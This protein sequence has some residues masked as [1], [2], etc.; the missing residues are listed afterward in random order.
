MCVA[1]LFCSQKKQISS[2]L[3]KFT[4]INSISF[5]IRDPIHIAG[6]SV[7]EIEDRNNKSRITAVTCHP[8]RFSLTWRGLFILRTSLWL[9][10]EKEVNWSSCSLSV[11][12]FRR[13]SLMTGDSA[14]RVCA[15]NWNILGVALFVCLTTY[16]IIS[17][18]W[19][20]SECGQCSL[21]NLHRCK[22]FLP[23]SVCTAVQKNAVGHAEHAWEKI[24][25]LPWWCWSD[26]N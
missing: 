14:S 9:L 20:V 21:N 3:V 16:Q 25:F 12:S 11:I 18:I 6:L 10:F 1:I 4:C 23:I 22:I 26:Y 5:G 17:P 2:S 15:S 24:G 7:F 13:S 8:V 19:V